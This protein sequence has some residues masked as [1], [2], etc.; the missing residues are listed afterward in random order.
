[1]SL[2]VDLYLFIRRSPLEMFHGSLAQDNRLP[3]HVLDVLGGHSHRFPSE[4]ASL[5]FPELFLLA[6]L[7]VLHFDFHS[8]LLHQA[9]ID[10]YHRPLHTYVRTYKLTQARDAGTQT[11]GELRFVEFCVPT[12]TCFL[13]VGVRAWSV[14][15]HIRVWKITVLLHDSRPAPIP[16][17]TNLDGE[18]HIIGGSVVYRFPRCLSSSCLL[19][20]N[21]CLC[22][23]V[24]MWSARCPQA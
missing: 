19:L 20:V 7:G 21:S 6:Y 17:V 23:L 9:R 13:V 18:E 15:L 24:P 8:C 11:R 10:M 16:S 2:R 4:Y 5:R 12:F 22:S 1:M 14:T 3:R